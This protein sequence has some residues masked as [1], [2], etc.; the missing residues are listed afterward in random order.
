MEARKIVMKSVP[1]VGTGFRIK[2]NYTHAISDLQS[3]NERI[4]LYNPNNEQDHTLVNVHA[5]RNNDN[6]KKT[7]NFWNIL[8]NTITKINPK[9][10]EILLGGFNAQ[11]DKNTN[12]DTQ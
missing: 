3:I 11:I 9:H 1:H 2:N 5:T 12:I 4:S 6:R 7:D 8:Y 10:A